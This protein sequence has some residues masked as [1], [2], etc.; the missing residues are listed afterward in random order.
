MTETLVV[1]VQGDEPLIDPA[2]VGKVA[3]VLADDVEASIATAGHPIDDPDEIFNPS[4]VRWCATGG[5]HALYFPAPASPG[6]ETPSPT[7]QRESSG[8]VCDA[9]PCRPVCYRAAFLRRYADLEPSP[10]GTGSARAVA[11]RCGMALP[12]PGA[13]DRWR[14]RLQ[15]SIRRRIS[16]GCARCLIGRT[17]NALAAE[18]FI[19][20]A[21]SGC[22]EYREGICD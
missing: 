3:Q 15:V 16:S 12:H 20:A 11:G 2:L 9:A 6:R 4:V 10:I 21:R 1:N 7:A 19:N 13:D 22:R 17:V 8:R 14:S 18:F 5:E